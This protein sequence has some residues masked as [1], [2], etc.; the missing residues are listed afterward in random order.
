MFPII[1]EGVETVNHQTYGKEK[2]NPE[3]VFK[4]AIEILN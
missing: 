2:I 3:E 4:K 1:P